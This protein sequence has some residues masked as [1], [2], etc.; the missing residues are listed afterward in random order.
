MAQIKFRLEGGAI[1][2]LVLI[3]IN[4]EEPQR[5]TGD[6]DWVAPIS[7]SAEHVV[8]VTSDG[9]WEMVLPAS[10]V[11][12]SGK[13]LVVFPALPASGPL[14]WWHHAHRATG[15]GRGKGMRIGIIDEAL[16]PQ[17]SSSCISHIH[18]DGA[19]AWGSASYARALNPLTE[20]AHAVCSLI[21][22]RA[23]ASNGYAGIAPEAEIFFAAASADDSSRLSVP[24]VE[25]SIAFLAENRQCDVLSISAGDLEDPS[26]A[27]ETAVN[28]AAEYGTLCFFAAGNTGVPLY[29]AIYPNCLAVAALGREGFAPPGTTIELIDNNQTVP[30]SVGEYYVWM[31]SARGPEID[32]CAPGV[33]VIWSRE[34]HSAVIT[35]GTS[36]ACPLAAATA[37]LVLQ[38]DASYRSMN[39]DRRR[40]NYALGLLEDAANPLG[41][42]DS[43]W[44][45][46]L[47]QL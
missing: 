17:L 23:N 11:T 15:P 46:G 30:L 10:V 9:Y 27:L 3:L 28:M 40:Y 44:K 2:E 32:F 34:H 42:G 36:F 24:R 29:P 41:E 5:V 1:P 33:G 12:A 16:A 45:Y 35:Y 4:G 7:I 31:Y 19:A 26:P 21:A 14:G 39:P 38:N 22:S 13:L 43:H 25:S 6:E 8:F 20:H 47:L 37:V 18:N